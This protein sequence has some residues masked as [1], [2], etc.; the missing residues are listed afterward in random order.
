LGADYLL[1]GGND[2]TGAEPSELFPKIEPNSLDALFLEYQTKLR[3][4]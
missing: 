1:F 3:E 2:K 4:I